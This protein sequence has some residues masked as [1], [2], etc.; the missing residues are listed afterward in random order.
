MEDDKKYNGYKNKATWCAALWF[1]N[2]EFLYH[3]AIKNKNVQ[4]LKATFRF[5]YRGFK[6]FFDDNNNFKSELVSQIDWIEVF[7]NTGNREPV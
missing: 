6:D 7:N 4:E 3:Q 2:D 5:Y 1:N